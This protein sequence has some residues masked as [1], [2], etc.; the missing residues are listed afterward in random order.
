MQGRAVLLF[1]ENTRMTMSGEE[2]SK[3]FQKLDAIEKEAGHKLSQHARDAYFLALR[4]ECEPL[5][6]TRDQIVNGETPKKEKKARGS[7]GEQRPEA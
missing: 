5:P 7:K 4:A 1:H 6:V 2:I 3:E